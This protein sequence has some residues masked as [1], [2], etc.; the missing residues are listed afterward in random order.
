[1]HNQEIRKKVGQMLMFG[2]SGTE[3]NDSIR[4][5]IREQKIGGVILFAANILDPEQV[6]RLCRDLQQWNRQEGSEFPLLIAIDQEGGKVSRIPWLV[7]QYPDPVLLSSPGKSPDDAYHFGYGLGREL[8]RLGITVNLAP[9]LDVLSNQENTL[10]ALRCLGK[11]AEK[12]ADLG[13]CLIRGLHSGGV[14]ATGKHFPGHG[15]V[16]A[17]S[18]YQL[19]VS[20]CTVETLRCRELIPFI[21]AVQ[22]GLDM[23]MTAHIQYT[24]L[25]PEYPA[26]LS[27]KI[28][29]GLLRRELG[30]RGIVITDDMTMKAITHHF[31]PR[32]A[33]L[34][35]AGAGVDI[36]LVCHEPDQ[37][38]QAWD[39]LMAGYRDDEKTRSSIEQASQRIIEFKAKWQKL[40]ALI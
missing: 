5:V 26:T 27:K 20:D 17:D 7:E 16:R 30:F 35:A 14:L 21:R 24:C 29:Q 8:S 36:V 10:L 28:I 23:I 6:R 15:D 31:T 4:Q 22:A 38:L 39:A 12:V 32:E 33:A 1:M 11:E 19:P 18:H 40:F 9:V 2:F 13:E 34:A 25:D 3:L 37:Q